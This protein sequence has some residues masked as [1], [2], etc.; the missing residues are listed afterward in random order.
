[1]IL[2]PLIATLL[3]VSLTELHWAHIQSLSDSVSQFKLQGFQN[4]CYCV[5]FS[6]M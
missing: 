6:Y 2:W 5:S 1:M 3:T 4:S